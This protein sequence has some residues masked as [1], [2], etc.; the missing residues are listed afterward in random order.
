MESRPTVLFLVL[1][2]FSRIVFQLWRI[3]TIRGRMDGIHR[4]GMWA[5]SPAS[6]GFLAFQ[7]FCS[8]FSAFCASPVLGTAQM[9]QGCRVTWP[10]LYFL[11]HFLALGPVRYQAASFEIDTQDRRARIYF[12]RPCDRCVMRFRLCSELSCVKPGR[13]ESLFCD[14]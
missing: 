11:G 3:G 2:P 14:R 6:S 9:L 8:P 7:L 13:A 5:K 10:P 1:V 4:D 12:V